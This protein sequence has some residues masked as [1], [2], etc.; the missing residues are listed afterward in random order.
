MTQAPSKP[1]G[2]EVQPLLVW[3]VRL[4]FNEMRAFVQQVDDPLVL[5]KLEVHLLTPIRWGLSERAFLT[6]LLQ[7][8][9]LG[10]EAYLPYALL[11]EAAARRKL[12]YRTLRR[13]CDDPFRLRGRGLAENLYNRL[14]MLAERDLALRRS[15]PVL[16]KR[17]QPFYRRVRNPIFHGKQLATGAVVPVRKAFA[18]FG[19]LYSWIDSWHEFPGKSGPVLPSPRRDA[20]FRPRGED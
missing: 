14:P 3:N 5:E 6:L 11:H 1:F 17:V 18:L 4:E 15:C 20:A 2:L 13:F 12:D 10:I 19:D 16:W 7:R 8:A 9:I